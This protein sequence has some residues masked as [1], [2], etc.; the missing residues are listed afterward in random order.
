MEVSINFTEITF[1]LVNNGHSHLLVDART[2]KH[3]RSPSS[4]RPAVIATATDHYKQLCGK[5]SA[6]ATKLS[7]HFAQLQL[8]FNCG[9]VGML[10]PIFIPIRFG[11]DLARK[12]VVNVFTALG[13]LVDCIVPAHRSQQ[14]TRR[15][16]SRCV[17]HCVFPH[18]I[19]TDPSGDHVYI[20]P[21]LHEGSRFTRA[22]RGGI[23]V[24][25]GFC[26]YVLHSR[27]EPTLPPPPSPPYKKRWGQ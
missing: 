4:T 2:N 7:L 21:P 11:C 6:R 16:H 20:V 14:Q 9:F 5:V 15:P 17:P 13:P 27:I 8:I 26:L 1:S 18:T 23:W 25:F 22:M 12:F 3:S 24:L 10:V 19:E